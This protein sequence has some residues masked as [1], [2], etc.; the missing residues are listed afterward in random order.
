MAWLMVEHAEA[1]PVEDKSLPEGHPRRV[2]SDY[3]RHLHFIV[4]NLTFDPE[5]KITRC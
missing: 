3:D 4:P 2:S 1:R 5:E